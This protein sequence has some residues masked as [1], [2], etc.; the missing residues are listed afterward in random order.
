M[1]QTHAF[2]NEDILV[3]LLSLSLWSVGCL[4]IILESHANYLPP[5]AWKMKRVTFILIGSVRLYFICTVGRLLG[6]LG[7]GFSGSSGL[8]RSAVSSVRDDYTNH[9]EGGCG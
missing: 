6:G 3:L 7:N 5:Y 1:S 9:G 2:I 4:L 8:L